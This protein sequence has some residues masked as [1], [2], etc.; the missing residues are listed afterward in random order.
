[1][2]TMTDTSKEAVEFYAITSKSGVH[3]GLWDSERLAMGV[4]RE[5]SDYMIAKLVCAKEHERVCAERDAL[6]AQ[7]QAARECLQAIARKASGGGGGAIHRPI[8]RESTEGD[9]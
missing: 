3:I 1:M 4:L 8:W 9:G 2:G 6:C 7:L 5:S